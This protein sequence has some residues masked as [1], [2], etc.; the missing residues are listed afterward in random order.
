MTSTF[1]RRLCGFFSSSFLVLAS[2]LVAFAAC[3]IILRILGHRGSPRS[4]IRNVRFVHDPILDWRKLPGEYSEGKIVYRFNDSGFRDL[5]H[6]APKPPGTKR[7]IVLG[8]SVTEGFG[9]EWNLVFA[10][11]VQSHLGAGFEV[12]N[13]AAEGLNT[14]Q[15]IHLFA[16]EGVAYKPDILILNFVLNDCDFYS[17]FKAG[18]RFAAEK[19]SRITLLNLHVTPEFKSLLKSSAFLFFVKQHLEDVVGRL[20]GIPPTDYYTQLWANAGNRQRVI[21]GLDQLSEL[22]RRDPFKVVVV[23][24]PLITNYRNYGY[25]WVHKWVEQQAAS[26]GFDTI[27]LLPRFAP[28]P[29]RELQITWEDSVHPNALGHRIAAEAFLEWFGSQRSQM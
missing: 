12:I 8:D 22:R 14:P 3:E 15:E 29:F 26:R 23:I 6:Q 7:I 13:L 21:L 1:Q 11:Y 20:K 25:T 28:T 2:L 16:Q 27:D 19:E 5:N 24:W 4:L 9:V 10:P 17:S 18:Q